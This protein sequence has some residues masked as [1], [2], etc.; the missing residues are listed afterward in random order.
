VK[1]RTGT[2]GIYCLKCA[3]GRDVKVIDV[4]ER[5]ITGRETIRHYCHQCKC[6]SWWW[7]TGGPRERVMLIDRE[8]RPKDAKVWPPRG[9]MHRHCPPRR[10]K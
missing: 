3:C 10:V 6:I 2:V 9:W 4:L 7:R 8:E 1:N 5:A